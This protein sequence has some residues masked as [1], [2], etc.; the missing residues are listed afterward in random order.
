MPTLNVT[1]NAR[2][3]P[4]LLAFGAALLL[5]LAAALAQTAIPD[6]MLH[7]QEISDGDRQVMKAVITA[8][9]AGLESKNPSEIKKSRDVLVAPF[10]KTDGLSVSFRAAY[11]NALIEHG[12]IDKT[13]A[14]K[15]NDLAAAN[16]LRIAGQAA[17]ANTLNIILKG[18]EDTRPQVRYAATVAARAAFM[19]AKTTPALSGDDLSK[20]LI[21]LGDIAAA[22]KAKEPADGAIQ[23]MIAARETAIPSTRSLAIDRLARAAGARALKIAK[24]GD[25]DGIPSLLRVAG[26]LRAD[27][28]DAS[29]LTNGAKQAI[30]TFA[31]QALTAVGAVWKDGEPTDALSQTARAAAAAA[32]LVYTEPPRTFPVGDLVASGKHDQFETELQKT[33]GVLQAAPYNVKPEALKP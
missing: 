5:P 12:H 21:A 18:L 13:A 16:A 6:E 33:L 11:A 22:D 10:E 25:A 1:T 15:D 24:D 3:Y 7:K 23:A 17:T 28:S 30:A 14:D 29:T 19:A 9:V 2:R 31:A 4:R 32:A 20:A 27:L 8:N 26:A